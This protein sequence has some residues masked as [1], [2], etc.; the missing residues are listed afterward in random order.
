MSNYL[1]FL[2]SADKKKLMLLLE[3]KK[4][5]FWGVYLGAPGGVVPLKYVKTFVA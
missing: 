3:P 4:I 1:Y 5:D 2:T